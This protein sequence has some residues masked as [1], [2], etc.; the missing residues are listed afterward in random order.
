[1]VLCISDRIM[2]GLCLLGFTSHTASRL[3]GAFIVTASGSSNLPST[4][5]WQ[6]NNVRGQWKRALTSALSVGA[7]GIGGIVGGTVF[8]TQDAPHYHPGIIA[9]LIA[10][11]LM[12]LISLALILK[13]HRANKRAE[14][15]MD[16][17]EGLESFRYTL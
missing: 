6:S 13:Y 10:N 14:G 5:S 2:T 17:V 8:R 9:T 3:V 12:I 7:G 16:L 4:L 11:F 15:G 1:M